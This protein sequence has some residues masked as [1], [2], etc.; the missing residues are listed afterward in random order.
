MAN[1][2]I[3][4]EIKSAGIK[5]WQIADKLGYYDSTFSKKLRKELPENEKEKIRS[6]I[7]ELSNKGAI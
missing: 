1:E 6:I 4:N 2:I 3:K 5:F 7:D